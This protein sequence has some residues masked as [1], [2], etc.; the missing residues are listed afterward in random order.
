MDTPTQTNVPA[1]SQT[2]SV[3]W[4]RGIVFTALFAALFAAFSW[5]KVPLGFTTVP[6]TLQTLAVMLAGGLLGARYG[7]WSIMT[8]VILSTIGLPLISATTGL[9]LLLG[10]TG[11]Y[12]WMFP[13][14]ALFI[15]LVSDSLFRNRKSLSTKSFALLLTG[16]MVFG[17]LLAYIGGVPWLAYKANLSMSAALK[18]GCYPF[19]AGD[20]VKAVVAA[21]LI[22]ILRPLLPKFR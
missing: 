2:R 16:I 17:V 1:S 3:Y 7:F 14:E 12:I 19:L 13:L 20:M 18:S 10:F 11:G 21:F 6:I 5:V 4:I 22:R 8:V 9:S 15:G